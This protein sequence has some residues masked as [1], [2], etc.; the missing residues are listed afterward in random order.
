MGV[1]ALT[2]D[3]GQ[4]SRATIPAAS[5]APERTSTVTFNDAVELILRRKGSAVFTIG[6]DATVYQALEQLAERDIGA[7]VVMDGTRLVG[8]ISERDYVRKV[9]L[10]GGSS[11]EMRVREIM[12]SPAMTVDP[13]TT[14]DECMQRKTDKR[15]RHLTV[16]DGERVV[17]I[18]SIG[19][20][21]N[22]MI[23]TQDDTIHQLEDY[24]TGRYPA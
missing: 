24:I 18:V 16:V 23:T 8:L 2:A 17:G 13:K 3:V 22:W 5:A 4:Q 7:L 11:K 6:P 1:H 10:K 20:L 15:C 12:C 14:V 21:V 9:I 19:D